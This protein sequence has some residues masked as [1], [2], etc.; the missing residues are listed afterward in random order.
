MDNFAANLKEV[1]DLIDQDIE[2]RKEIEHNDPTIT[3][4]CDVCNHKIHKHCLNG[5]CEDGECDVDD[6]D[7]RE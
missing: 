2:Y 7:D 3:V 4:I 6:F 5:K 1:N